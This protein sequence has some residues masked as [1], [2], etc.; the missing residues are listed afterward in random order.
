MAPPEVHEFEPSESSPKRCVICGRGEGS[1]Y[2]QRFCRGCQEYHPDGEHNPNAKPFCNRCGTAH[3]WG[4]HIPFDPL[5]PMPL[6]V[7][8]PIQPR[9][10][11]FDLA[12]KQPTPIP[13]TSR[14]VNTPP[15]SRQPAEGVPTTPSSHPSSSLTTFGFLGKSWGL[16]RTFASTATQTP[17]PSLPPRINDL[18]RKLDEVSYDYEEVVV[19]CKSIAA[20]PRRAMPSLPPAQCHT[21]LPPPPIPYATRPTPPLAAPTPLSITHV[22]PHC[23]DAVLKRSDN[24]RDASPISTCSISATGTTS[25]LVPTPS[26]SPPKSSPQDFTRVLA[27]VHSLRREASVLATPSPPKLRASNPAPRRRAARDGKPKGVGQDVKA[28]VTPPAPSN[29]DQPS[30]PFSF[31][32]SQS[33]LSIK[34][35]VE[36]E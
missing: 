26:P 36:P 21:P 31:S 1:P 23:F 33:S 32:F 30:R 8:P 27:R 10:P 17:L 14:T 7:S 24:V 2:H 35:S 34:V 4:Q 25:T 5:P 12:F 29:P 20:L 18:K 16:P 11:T 9:P 15:P 6:P 28:T 19:V 3:L 13:D 22:E